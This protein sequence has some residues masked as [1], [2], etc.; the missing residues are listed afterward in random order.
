MALGLT[1]IPW[2]LTKMCAI[3][4]DAEQELHPEAVWVRTRTTP[5]AVVSMQVGLG[6]PA[7]MLMVPAGGFEVKMKHVLLQPT[8]KIPNK[9]NAN[10]RSF[11]TWLQRAR[12]FLFSISGIQHLRTDVGSRRLGG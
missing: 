3:R 7:F 10:R 5:F 1:S 11:Q 6:S 8:S 2:R 9:G 12:L 4:L